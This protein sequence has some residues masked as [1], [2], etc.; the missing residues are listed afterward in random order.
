VELIAEGNYTTIIN[1][2]NNRIFELMKKL[3]HDN[4]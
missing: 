4:K 1:I 3:K 2:K